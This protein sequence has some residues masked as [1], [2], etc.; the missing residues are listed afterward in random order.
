MPKQT[1][2]NAKKTQDVTK[3]KKKMINPEYHLYQCKAC[4]GEV[5]DESRSQ[6][7]LVLEEGGT[8]LARFCPTHKQALVLIHTKK[9]TKKNHYKYLQRTGRMLFAGDEE[10][11]LSLRSSTRAGT[12]TQAVPDAEMLDLS[13]FDFSN[14]ADD[15]DVEGDSDGDDESSADEYFEKC[16][17]FNHSMRLTGDG[18]SPGYHSQAR[19]IFNNLD[20]THRIVKGQRV[21]GSAANS[22]DKQTLMA[23]KLGPG[24]GNKLSA[25]VYMGLTGKT[26]DNKAEWCH[27]I[28]DCLGGMTVA[29]NLF[30]GSF[31]CNSYMEAIET[32]I[33]G[34]AFQ[35]DI[36]VDCSKAHCGSRVVYK[37]SHKTK[38]M[39]WTIDAQ[40]KY[41]N[42]DD[43]GQVF[44]EA[45]EFVKTSGISKGFG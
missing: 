11:S 36:T 35:L 37:I 19:T 42:A 4:A 27:V 7:W 13:G 44:N 30:A 22:L 15:S 45:Q 1:S 25:S 5:G 33:K 24:L 12:A 17:T 16:S 9:S 29:E 2:K 18:G 26:K 34:H 32:S 10:R 14:Q 40:A 41:F 31:A 8:R 43:Q 20:A 39:T 21:Q 6:F 23:K 28:A 38:S 3:F